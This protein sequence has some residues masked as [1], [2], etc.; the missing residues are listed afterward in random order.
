MRTDDPVSWGARP[1]LIPLVTIVALIAASIALTDVALPSSRTPRLIFAAALTFGLDG[2]LVLA[3]WLGGRAAASRNDGWART[4]GWRRPRWSDLKW[5]AI[6]IGVTFGARIVVGGIAN[7]LTHGRAGKEAQN[8]QI[9]HISVLG[10]IVL[11]LVVVVWA[12][13]IEELLFRGLLLRTFMRRLSFWPSAAISTAIFA[14]LHTYEV[15]TLAG[16]IT[17]A[18]SVATLGLA[19]CWLNRMAD[20]LVPGIIVHATFNALAV[21]YIA[22]QAS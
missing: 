16:A 12:P 17:L 22:V 1:I 9:D 14:I 2:L 18:A 11:S 13:L 6:G 19:N 20:S 4:F 10:L 21:V 15:D 8:I 3:V 5:A 7:G